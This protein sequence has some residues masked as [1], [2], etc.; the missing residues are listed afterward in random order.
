MAEAGNSARAKKA[1]GGCGWPGGLGSTTRYRYR[2]SPATNRWDKENGGERKEG[3]VGKFTSGGAG[4]VAR[5][6]LT[7]AEHGHGRQPSS[8][9]GGFGRMRPG[10]REA[11][12]SL[13]NE[14]AYLGCVGRGQMSD[15]RGRWGC[16]GTCRGG[17][18]AGLELGG[19]VGVAISMCM[20]AS[21]QAS[22]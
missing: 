11:P 2:R 4:T 1:R 19:D 3:P 22:G 16:V 17:Q 8:T 5:L 14:C 20:R 13:K 10:D 12:A 21:E 18:G 7:V 15:A 9:D 6:C